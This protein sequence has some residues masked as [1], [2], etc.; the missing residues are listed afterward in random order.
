MAGAFI[1]RNIDG[2]YFSDLQISKREEEKYKEDEKNILPYKPLVHPSSLLYFLPPLVK[3]YYPIY[4]R[5][6]HQKRGF[7]YCPEIEDDNGRKAIENNIL[8]NVFPLGPIRLPRQFFMLQPKIPGM[9]E[10]IC[11][12]RSLS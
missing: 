12:K 1:L 10:F 8:C 7:H 11:G 6:Y 2:F 5:L 9:G 4:D 3:E